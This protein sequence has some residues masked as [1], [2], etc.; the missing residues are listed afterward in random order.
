L[1]STFKTIQSSDVTTSKTLLY[2]AIPL[3]GS[4]MSGTYGAWGTAETNIKN[5]AHG[6]FSSVYDY[7]YLSSSANHLFDM[8]VGF[9]KNSAISAST[10]VVQQ[11]KKI[12]IYNQ[13]AQMLMGHDS[14]GSIL[15]FDSDGNLLAGGTKLT[16][17][18]F[19]NFA[20][21][22]VKDEIKKGSFNMSIGKTTAFENANNTFLNLT[23]NGAQNS[24]FTNSPAGEYGIL[25]ASSGQAAGSVNGLAGLIF[26]QA[27][28]AVL[29]ASVFAGQPVGM[30]A[31]DVDMN[32][33]S[34]TL[35]E[36]LVANEISSS[37]DAIRHRLYDVSFSNTTELNS[38]IYFLRINHNDGN[39]SSNPTYLSASRI[40][41]KNSSQ[42]SPVT[43]IC[44]AGLYSSDNALLAVCKLSECISKG[45]DKE[46]ILRARLDF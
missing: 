22:L 20:R 5:Y 41:T 17:C 38:T 9:A 1:A 29:T 2:E 6:I 19:I 40:V 46:Y 24:Y 16:E 28:V 35:K 8:T 37:C 27:G 21:L 14:T 7:S 30:M 11:T 36:M 32:P 39:Y 26:Y 44:G 4:L 23:D 25:S 15:P 10:P 43:Y 33:A 3:T 31:A 45:P 12:N 13:T 18:I 34:S 42:D